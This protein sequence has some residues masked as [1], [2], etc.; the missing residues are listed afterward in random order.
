M[1]TAHLFQRDAEGRPIT[2]VAPKTPRASYIHVPFCAHRCGYCNFTVVAGRDDLVEPYLTAIERELN[3][4]GEPREVETLYLGGGTPT[5]L[6]GGQL[7]RL[8]TI[9]LRWHPL[10]STD[11]GQLTTDKPEFSVEANP[12][13]LD[14]ET[15]QL[16]AKY[17][18]TRVSLGAPIVR[19]A[20]V[21]AFGARS[22]SGPHRAGSQ[23][24]PH[25]PSRRL[26]GPDLRRAGRIARRLARRSSLSFATRARP[27]F[28]LRADLRARR[29]FLAPSGARRVDSHR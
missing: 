10:A 8:L 19:S 6:K 1:R 2:E 7:E 14:A 18:V 26:F 4:L 17:G 28:N 16:L 13:D 11:N 12:A 5:Q 22:S 23:D 27:R 3:A 15:V 29:R 9:V 21:T 25:R 20:Q 24:A